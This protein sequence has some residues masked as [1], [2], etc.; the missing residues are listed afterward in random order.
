RR[1]NAERFAV[2]TLLASQRVTV[3]SHALCP[4]VVFTA[5][6]VGWPEVDLFPVVL[7]DVRN[8][9]IAGFGIEVDHVGIAYAISPDFRQ[10]PDL[11]P[12][13]FLLGDAEEDHETLLRGFDNR[14]VGRNV[15]SPVVVVHVDVDPEQLAQARAEVLTGLERIALP[16]AISGGDVE[17]SV[18]TKSD[19]ATVVVVVRLLDPH[20]HLGGF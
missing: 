3:R 15:V 6:A 10:G 16:A 13:E 9:E 8:I 1:K 4:P 17:V 18:G 14:I 11:D 12:S 7:A 19:R 2:E 20:D 5:S